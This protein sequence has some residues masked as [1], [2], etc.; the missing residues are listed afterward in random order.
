[1][2]AEKGLPIGSKKESSDNSM[3]KPHN[4]NSNKSWKIAITLT[5]LLAILA[6]ALSVCTL[7]FQLW[8]HHCLLKKDFSGE[9]DFY[10]STKEQQVLDKVSLL[11]HIILYIK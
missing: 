7:A 8:G 5:V 2:D 10:N 6:C 3:E 1:M 11:I 9:Y 4:H